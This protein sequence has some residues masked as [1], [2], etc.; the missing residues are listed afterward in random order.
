[1]ESGTFFH[2]GTGP[3]VSTA[4]ASPP[5]A[6]LP[7]APAHCTL[8]APGALPVACA[9]T[10]APSDACPVVKVTGE[11]DAGKPHVRFDEGVLGLGYGRA[12]EAPP[13]ERG[14]NR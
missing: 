9:G 14:G 4:Q 12:R 2:R 5:D 10:V 1:M 8:G 7:G 13:T 3:D 11:P 6:S